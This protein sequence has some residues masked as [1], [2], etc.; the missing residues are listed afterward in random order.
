MIA[1]NIG[2]GQRPFKPPWWNYDIQEE[3]WKQLTL[4]QRCKWVED[5]RWYGPGV[6]HWDIICLH[7]VLEHFG[8]NEADSLIDLC[9][10]A[11]M[12]GGSLLVF[13]PDMRALAQGWL[14]RRVTDQI[15]FTNIYGAYMGDEADRHRWGYSH[16]S[17]VEY[18][19]KWDWN[20]L[21]HW[22]G[23]K[24]EG[25]DIAEDWWI[26]GMECVK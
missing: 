25:A 14:T 6:G 13:V 21:K 20:K 9:H 15:Y 10:R 3:K 5:D 19:H 1:L 7:H 4:E 23:R 8:C 24:I 18:L 16:G 2:S 11:L 17:L 22:D 12:P 26:L